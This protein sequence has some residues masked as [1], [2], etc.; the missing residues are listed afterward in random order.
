MESNWFDVYMKKG[1]V[2]VVLLQI[3]I[4]AYLGISIYK[5]KVLSAAVVSI[6]IDNKNIQ[7]TPNPDLQHYYEPK[8]NSEYQITNDLV[9]NNATYLINSDSLNERF[10]YHHERDDH[11]YRIITLG[12]SYTFGLYVN[13]AENWTEQL[14]DL[15]N[16]RMKCSQYDSYEVINL[17]VHGYDIEYA[18]ERFKVRGMRYTPDLVLW[19]TKND[20]FTQVNEALRGRLIEYEQEMRE[21]GEYEKKLKEGIAHPAW[22]KAL[23][24]T[25]S[26]LGQDK[27]V[28]MIS[29][30][31]EEFASIYSDPLVILNFEYESDEVKDFYREM[32]QIQPKGSYF[33]GL[34]NIYSNSK[35]FFEGDGHPTVAGHKIIAEDIYQYLATHNLRCN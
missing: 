2:F 4:I 5:K 28:E 10:N 34:T 21:S 18:V 22:Q 25:F 33:G 7:Y 27:I 24:E 3:A 29:S 20:D 15:L 23:E 12:D 13:T 31:F 16:T 9:K 32:S 14:E 19:L 17:G 26:I 8:E 6:P 1:I 30:D 35:N 11:V